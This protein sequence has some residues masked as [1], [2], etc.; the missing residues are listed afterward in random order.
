MKESTYNSLHNAKDNIKSAICN[1]YSA[2]SDLE[3]I[4]DHTDDEWN[5]MADIE[6]EIIRLDKNLISI[7]KLI[8]G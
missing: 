2:K 7:I 6:D 1:L 5:L 3:E 4:K 8:H